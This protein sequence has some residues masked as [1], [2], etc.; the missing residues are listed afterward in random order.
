MQA[1]YSATVS[2]S[3]FTSGRNKTQRFIES[4]EEHSQKHCT[5][6]RVSPEFRTYS[7]EIRDRDRPMTAGAIASRRDMRKGRSTSSLRPVSAAVHGPRQI[8]ASSSLI[9]MFSDKD[10]PRGMRGLPASSLRRRRP[11][12]SG[13]FQAGAISK[14]LRFMRNRS[15]MLT[16]AS[17]LIQ[18]YLNVSGNNSRA[19]LS[20]GAHVYGARF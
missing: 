5:V 2:Q 7:Q 6:P 1:Y 3:P 15:G 14:D 10:V 13:G 4:A 20:L 17:S 16:L 12:S 11:V 18:T 19:L 8:N 9:K